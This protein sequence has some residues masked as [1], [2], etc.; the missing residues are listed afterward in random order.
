MTTALD[1]TD[2]RHVAG[3]PAAGVLETTD[4]HSGPSQPSAYGPHDIP[5]IAS[6][7]GEEAV[8]VTRILRKQPT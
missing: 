1:M 7:L 6:L 5:W 4:H 8:T 2:P 3:R